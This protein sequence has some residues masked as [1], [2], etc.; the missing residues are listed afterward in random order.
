MNRSEIIQAINDHKE[1][2]IGL[3]FDWPS[4]SIDEAT[5]ATL[6]EFLAELD[7]YITEN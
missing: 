4:Q 5:T 3:G 1:R 2:A 7:S 6:Q